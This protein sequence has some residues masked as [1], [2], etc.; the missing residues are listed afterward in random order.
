MAGL[1]ALGGLELCAA[2][3]HA[4]LENPL[5]PELLYRPCFYEA[6]NS[7]GSG[8]GALSLPGLVVLPPRAGAGAGGLVGAC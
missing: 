6:W 1:G 4:A 8:W 3:L 7:G 5:H 2:F